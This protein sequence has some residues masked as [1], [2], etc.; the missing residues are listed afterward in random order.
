MLIYGCR[1]SNPRR[2][3]GRQACYH[4]TTTVFTTRAGLEPAREYPNGFQVHRF[5]HSATVSSKF[6]KESYLYFPS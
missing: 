1:E 3:L 5:N 6:L 2:L 4:Y